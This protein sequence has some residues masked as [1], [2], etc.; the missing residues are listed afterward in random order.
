MVILITYIKSFLIFVI[1]PYLTP[2]VRTVRQSSFARVIQTIISMTCEF[3]KRCWESIRM[4]LTTT[5]VWYFCTI[6]E[7]A[8]LMLCAVRWNVLFKKVIVLLRLFL[9]LL[10]QLMTL[11]NCNSFTAVQ[12]N[13]TAHLCNTLQNFFSVISRSFN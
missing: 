7:I 6:S 9:E 3:Y 8:V 4:F 11:K 2:K 5:M 1:T 12:K 10:L 13:V